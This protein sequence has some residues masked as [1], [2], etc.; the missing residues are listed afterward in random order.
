MTCFR[1][2]DVIT[3]GIPL[4][5]GNPS[6]FVP[7]FNHQFTFGRGAKLLAEGVVEQ[8]QTGRGKKGGARG[9]PRGV[10]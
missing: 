9:G 7:I 3:M 10:G 5:R 6:D 8:G 2:C 1:E 4:K